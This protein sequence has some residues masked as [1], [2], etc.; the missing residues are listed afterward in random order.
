MLLAPFY[1]HDMVDFERKK[2]GIPVEVRMDRPCL[3]GRQCPTDV[4]CSFC[5]ALVEDWY[6]HGGKERYGAN[7]VNSTVTFQ[8]QT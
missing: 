6:E 4:L 8:Q 7:A 2:A 3:M 1:H 5:H